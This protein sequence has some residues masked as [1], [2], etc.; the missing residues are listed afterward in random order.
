MSVTGGLPVPG[1]QEAGRAAGLVGFV[2]VV[3]RGQLQ[4][5]RAG[6]SSAAALS[7]AD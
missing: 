1:K 5:Q 7:Q 6:P 3:Q 4:L 2:V